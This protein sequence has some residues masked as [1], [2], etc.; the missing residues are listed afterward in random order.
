MYSIVR[1]VAVR[2]A[3]MCS[4][5]NSRARSHTLSKSHTLGHHDGSPFDEHEIREP[6]VIVIACRM[7]TDSLRCIPCHTYLLFH[8]TLLYFFLFYFWVFFIRF[9][10]VVVFL[11]RIEQNHME[12]IPFYKFSFYIKFYNKIYYDSA[13]FSPQILMVCVVIFVLVVSLSLFFHF[14]CTISS[15]SGAL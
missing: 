7:Q 9:V 4:N 5:T 6:N 15:L 2:R 12:S 13:F 11:S 8:F 3:S 10:A 14:F 1:T